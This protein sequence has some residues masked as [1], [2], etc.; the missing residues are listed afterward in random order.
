[1]LLRTWL[2][3]RVLYSVVVA[4]LLLKGWKKDPKD[5]LD[6]QCVYNGKKW[7]KN[8]LDE[9]GEIRRNISIAS[10]EINRVKENRKLTKRGKKN[11]ALLQEKSLSVTQLITYIEKQKFR[12]RKPKAAFGRKKRQEEAK[13]LNDQFRTDPGRVYARINQIVAEDPDNA[14]P[15]YKAA[16]PTVEQSGRGRAKAKCSGTTDNLMIDRMVTL[17]CHRHKR[18]LSVAWIDVRKAFDSVDHGWLKKILRINRF[19]AWICQVVDNL[20]DSWNT[21]IA[22]KTMK[23]YELSPPI[24]FNRGLP[25]GDVLCSKSVPIFAILTLFA[26]IAKI[27]KNRKNRK[28]LNS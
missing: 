18:N 25:Q 16:S 2:V 7:K 22:V 3:N 11:R 1:M 12:L 23:G 10:A 14:H 8:Y 28:T 5:K 26:K 15:K 13:S 19:P 17:D 24:N 6:K 20:S 27:A 4:F 9:M 21:R